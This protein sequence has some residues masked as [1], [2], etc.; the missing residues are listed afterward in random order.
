MGNTC[1][2]VPAPHQL[3]GGASNGG[4]LKVSSIAAMLEQ[5]EPSADP[6]TILQRASDYL[7]ELNNAKLGDDESV[8]Y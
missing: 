2:I 3:S 7:A 8:F 6:N 1:V 4:Q 5:R